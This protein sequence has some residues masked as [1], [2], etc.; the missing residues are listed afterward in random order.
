MI[1]QAVVGLGSNI[2]P[3]KNIPEAKKI[4]AQKQK[5]IAESKFVVTK[6]IGSTTQ[7]DF[8]NG[9]LL[10]ETSLSLEDL[11]TDLKNIER[12]LGRHKQADKYAPRTIDLDI[13]VWNQTVIDHD[14]YERSF[15]KTAV[16]ELIPN[17]K[18]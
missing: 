5:V 3:S 16:L 2:E 7:P 14:F 15:L 8:L 10:I 13:V 4:I 6:P 9:A 11:K 17:L 1:N 18:Y 12:Q